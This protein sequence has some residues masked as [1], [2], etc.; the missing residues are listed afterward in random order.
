[1]TGRVALVMIPLTP[2]IE[3]I[4]TMVFKPDVLNVCVCSCLFDAQ[5]YRASSVSTSSYQLTSK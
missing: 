3:Q 4:T 1:M 5:G 2:G